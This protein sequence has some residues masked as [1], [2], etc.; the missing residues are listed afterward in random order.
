MSETRGG[1]HSTFFSGR[2]VR[3]GFPKCG[4][5][6]LIFASDREGACELKI[7]KLG[8]CGLKVSKFRG[9]RT[10]K[11]SKFGGLRA[12]NWAKIKAV[13]AKISKFSQKG[14][15]WTDTFCLKWDSCELQERREKG[16]FRAAHPHTPFLVSDLDQTSWTCF[17][18]IIVWKK[19]KYGPKLFFKT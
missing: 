19:W 13:K 11:N 8:A 16:V 15:F 14:V 5:C 17:W 3:P 7:S 18:N 12:K 4:V 6:E 2:G 9:L 10:E 1:G